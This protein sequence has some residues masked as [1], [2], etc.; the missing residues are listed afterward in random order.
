MH[1]QTANVVENTHQGEP[2]SAWVFDLDGTLSDPLEGMLASINHALESITYQPVS[3]AQMRLHIGPPLELTLAEFAGT[4]DEETIRLLIERYRSHYK[5][6]GY[7][8]NSLYPGIVDF[9]QELASRELPM[10]VCTAKTAPV[11]IRILEHFGIDHYF[12]FVSGGD[13]GITKS[14][15]L[16]KLLAEGAID[17]YALMLG[18]RRYDLEAAHANRLRCCAVSWGYGSE[19]ELQEQSPHF[20]VQNPKGLFDLLPGGHPS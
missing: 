3:A 16:E 2:V 4:D 5:E 8:Q 18:D 9:L 7:A 15:Q 14:S 11:A 19:Q 1:S 20:T 10:G 6:T 13:V 12:G 17:E